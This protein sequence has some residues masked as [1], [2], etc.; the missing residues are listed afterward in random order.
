MMALLLASAEIVAAA[1]RPDVSI[2]IDKA[3]AESIL[4]E[5]VK[6]AAPRNLE[7][8]DGYYSKINYYA[9]KPGKA[10]II[11]LHQA[12]PGS[13]DPQ[14]ELEMV[15]ASTGATKPLSGLG[16]RAEY[17]HGADSNLPA[18]AL[19]LYV[20]KGNTLIT[21]GLNGLDD[22]SLALE[23]ARSVAQKILEKL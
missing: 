21:V 9:L 12:A 8:G 7:G 19:M 13:P 23:K 2:V 15:R 10:L 16:D 4:G 17:A 11:R 1:G 20:A 18:H 5:T 22:D 14:Q 6:P 3:T